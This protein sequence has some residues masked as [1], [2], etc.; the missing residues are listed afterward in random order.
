MVHQL[1]MVLLRNTSSVAQAPLTVT[2]DEFLA[3]GLHPIFST[4]GRF[5]QVRN[6]HSMSYSMI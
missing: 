3:R 4:R 1:T 2:A 5:E 6:K